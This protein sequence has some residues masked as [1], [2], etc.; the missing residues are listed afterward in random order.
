MFLSVWT[1]SIDWRGLLF[2]LAFFFDSTVFYRLKPFG[3]YAFLSGLIVCLLDRQQFLYLSVSPLSL[4]A[5]QRQMASTTDKKGT[6]LTSRTD[7]IS[8]VHIWS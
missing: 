3:A 4:V 2:D 7:L 1:V 8:P 6:M 5:Q